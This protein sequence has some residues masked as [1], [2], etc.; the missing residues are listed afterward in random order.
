MNFQ[1]NENSCFADLFMIELR[2]QMNSEL[3]NI[4]EFLQDKTRENL[5]V[6]E[7]I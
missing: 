2:F 6:Y 5:I 7:V 4:N 1:M 3:T